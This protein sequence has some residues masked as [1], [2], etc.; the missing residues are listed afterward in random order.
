M[1]NKAL[2]LLLS[3]VMVV[4]FMP[5]MALT[6]F[7][8]DGEGSGPDY[9]ADIFFAI[10]SDETP[11]SI[12][13]VPG[14]TISLVPK[15]FCNGDDINADVTFTLVELE[16][17]SFDEDNIIEP[18]VTLEGVDFSQREGDGCNVASITGSVD[19]TAKVILDNK[20]AKQGC[21]IYRL[22][23][24]YEGKTYVSSD[25]NI[26]V[27]CHLSYHNEEILSGDGYKQ[28]T[29]R[30]NDLGEEGTIS[31][32]P[33]CNSEAVKGFKFEVGHYEDGEQEKFESEYN[34]EGK[35]SGD[36]LQLNRADIIEIIKDHDPDFVVRVYA[37][38]ENGT[39]IGSEDITVFVDFPSL[40][41]ECYLDFPSTIHFDAS[42]N[43]HYD[44]LNQFKLI[45][46]ET[47]NEIPEDRE[48]LFEF[49]FVDADPNSLNTK[50]LSD[51]HSILVYKNGVKPSVDQN[52]ETSYFNDYSQ[53]TSSD[54][55]NLNLDHMGKYWV[56]VTGA[57]MYGRGT[58]YNGFIIDSFELTDADVYYTKKPKA[59]FEPR[60]NGDENPVELVTEGAAETTGALSGIIPLVQYRLDNGVW[61]TDVPSTT[62]T[63][64]HTVYFRV[65]ESGNEGNVLIPEESVSTTL[66]KQQV[67]IKLKDV[68]KLF[69]TSDDLSY[70]N[71]VDGEAEE[72]ANIPEE[73]KNAI[74]FYRE[75]GENVNDEGYGI[76]AFCDAE[77]YEVLFHGG[78]FF[79][80]KADAYISSMDTIS[81]VAGEV[82]CSIE[83]R[84][85][86]GGDVSVDNGQG[87]DSK[88]NVVAEDG[89]LTI[90]ASEACNEKITLIAEDN[91]HNKAEKEINVIATDKALA[92]GEAGSVYAMA[93]DGSGIT[94]GCTL[95]V[96]EPASA[97]TSEDRTVLELG[98]DLRSASGS[99]IEE[100][101]SGTSIVVRVKLTEALDSLRGGTNPQAVCGS[102]TKDGWIEYIGEDAY[103]CFETSHLSNWSL[104]VEPAV[105][106]G[107]K[108]FQLD[109]PG[110]IAIT[111]DGESNIDANLGEIVL[112]KGEDVI[113]PSC[114]KLVFTKIGQKNEL[115]VINSPGKYKVKAVAIEGM[116]YKGSIEAKQRV[117]AHNH[118]FS[119]WNYNSEVHWKECS[120]KGCG[121]IEGMTEHS[122]ELQAKKSKY[123][124]SEASCTEYAK[125]YYSCECGAHNNETFTD[126]KSGLKQHNLVP[127]SEVPATETTYGWIE[128]YQCSACGKCFR[129]SKGKEQLAI[130]DMRFTLEEQ[131]AA[132]KKAKETATK[133]A[134]AGTT[135]VGATVATVAIVKTVDELVEKARAAEAE[136]E[137]AEVARLLEE[138]KTTAQQALNEALGGSQNATVNELFNTGYKAIESATT[139]DEVMTATVDA[140]NLINAAKTVVATKISQNKLTANKNGKIKVSFKNPGLDGTASYQIVRSTKKDFS[141]NK[142]TYSVKAKDQNTLTLT[143][144]KNLKKDTKYYYR[145]RAKVQ[146]SDG[147]VVWSKWSNVRSATCK[148]T[149][150]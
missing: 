60:Y 39:S 17:N 30:P 41:N 93:G 142:K 57:L 75:N 63:G 149:I 23:A 13:I 26:N 19:V 8:D 130:D 84:T 27:G 16:N 10:D 22:E 67:V 120:T 112:K 53:A 108:G 1:K 65:V 115:D 100:F 119:K 86:V 87:N 68:R 5:T 111:Q 37:K 102:E 141:K 126:T 54:T 135:I 56:V 148:K 104:S 97:E 59:I 36:V 43:N 110:T 85:N 58:G 106:L 150:K 48:N 107:G 40:Y 139:P 117:S 133:I 64:S 12:D 33:F 129:D 138:A 144:A 72:N 140:V 6:A 70:D 92:D 28:M 123:L 35:V 42:K 55:F 88:L 109:V 2:A 38:G 131:E 78:R 74:T 15:L 127:V 73:V 95:V 77:N 105:N 4:T 91:N 18:I 89:I 145:V 98:I 24:E 124:A 137:A 29:V 25:C 79:I 132:Q 32:D 66:N 69:G 83:Y 134:I 114:Y 94:E 44:V 46:K 125:Y 81:F 21:A 99:L 118:K 50:E 146:L 11:G 82:P 14:Q 7:A 9:W 62:V 34:L 71:V 52:D 45:S 121:K 101:N 31:I 61:Q 103:F 49:R 143:N 90:K 51:S 147:T 136:R 80:D 116:G 20:V 122:F 47:G 76:S 128:H 113:D 3:L 96:G